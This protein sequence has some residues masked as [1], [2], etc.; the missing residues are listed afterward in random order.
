MPETEQ[1][2]DPRVEQI[3]SG[4]VIRLLALATEP[5]LQS[6]AKMAEPY[7]ALARQ[8]GVEQ[9][10]FQIGQYEVTVKNQ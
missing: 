3:K 7:M 8:N 4:E 1:S 9:V 10:T 5:P 6:L 2:V